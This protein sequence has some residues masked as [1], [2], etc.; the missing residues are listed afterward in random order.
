VT[1]PNQCDNDRLL[2]LAYIFAQGVLRLHRAGHVPFGPNGLSAET[3]LQSA[4]QDLAIPASSRL[5]VHC[6][7]RGEIAKQRRV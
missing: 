5:S 4:S 6:G 3:A 2:Q 7:K 1:N